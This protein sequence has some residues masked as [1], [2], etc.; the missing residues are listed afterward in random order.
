MTCPVCNKYCA[1]LQAAVVRGVYLSER[2]DSCLSRQ[3]PGE[4]AA[5]WNRDRQKED[6]RKD[7]LQRWDFGD[8]NEIDHDWARVYPKEAEAY[9]GKDKLEDSRI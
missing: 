3:K 2:C 1:T 6:Y 9:F 8:K 5:K 7:L 4:F